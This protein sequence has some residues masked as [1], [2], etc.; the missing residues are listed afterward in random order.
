MIFSNLERTRK[1]KKTLSLGLID[2]DS[3]NDANLD[4]ILNIVNKSGFDAVLVGGSSISDNKFQERVKRIKHNT[5]IPVIL[6][7]GD[8]KQIS[9]HADAILFTTLLNSR[10]TKYLIEEQLKSVEL[11]DEYKIEA[12]PTSYLLFKTDKR[13]AVEC[14]SK[15]KPINMNDEKEV[16]NYILV[17]AYLGKKIIFLEAGSNSNMTIDCELIKSISL[18]SDIPIIVGGGIKS[19]LSAKNIADA[20]ASYI[21]IGSMLETAKDHYKI[22]D[23]NQAVHCG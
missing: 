22:L 1:Q 21:V 20:G 23:I 14:I 3:K 8:S 17:S 11:I 4:N 2:P 9:P 10:S 19:I 6:F 5:S 16:R 18:I 13:S 12:I 15:S 7:P